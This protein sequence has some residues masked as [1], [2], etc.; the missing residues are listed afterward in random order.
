MT[1]LFLFP[2][3]QS[4]CRN[5]SCVIALSVYGMSFPR[6]I[7]LP[8]QVRFWP[9]EDLR[10][11]GRWPSSVHKQIECTLQPWIRTQYPRQTHPLGAAG[12]QPAD[13]CPQGLPLR[14]FDCKQQATLMLE[15]WHSKRP[16]NDENC[17]TLKQPPSLLIL[18][19]IERVRVIKPRTLLVYSQGPVGG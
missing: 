4:L 5:N 15:C 19:L 14:A 1:H 17:I 8:C 16:T 9:S 10:G 13:R 7:F 12:C 11:R 2:P 18:E 3:L 6:E